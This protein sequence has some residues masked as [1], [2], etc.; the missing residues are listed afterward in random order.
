MKK[1]A[2]ALIALMI[3][4]GARAQEV[5]VSLDNMNILYQGIDN[6]VTVTVACVDAEKV[7]VKVIE[8][9]GKV[10]PDEMDG[11]Y[12]VRPDVDCKNIKLAVYANT[13]DRVVEYTREFRVLPVLDPVITLNDIVYGGKVSREEMSQGVKVTAHKSDNLLFDIPDGAFRVESLEIYVGNKGFNAKGDT[14]PEEALAAIKRATRGDKV[15]VTAQVMMPDGRP[16]ALN[17]VVTLVK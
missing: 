4:L 2:I 7:S 16:R 12:I 11:H 3:A 10:K 8:G 13:G 6:P 9:K 17:C 15:Y 1:Q 5:N 14:F